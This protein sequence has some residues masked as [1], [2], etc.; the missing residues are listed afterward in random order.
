MPAPFSSG[1]ELCLWHWRDGIFSDTYHPPEGHSPWQDGQT[2]HSGNR[3]PAETKTWT[4]SL[5][6]MGRREKAGV[7]IK[8]RILLRIDHK[9]NW[10]ISFTLRAKLLRRGKFPWFLLPIWV[11]TFSLG[12]A[13]GCFLSTESRQR[14]AVQTSRAAQAALTSATAPHATATAHPGGALPG[15]VPSTA[16][17]EALVA[18]HGCRSPVWT[19]K[20]FLSTLP[21]QS[22][23]KMRD[24]RA[25]Q[26]LSKGNGNH[27]GLPASQYFLV[28]YL[29][30]TT[31]TTA[32]DK[33]LPPLCLKTAL[34]RQCAT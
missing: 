4:G 26:P 21:R 9:L 33:S 20:T 12:S 16:T 25:S 24:L 5:L 29:I 31:E 14:C 23:I 30:M 1:T 32:E 6:E 10:H 15:P 17:L 11:S 28:Q 19:T 2:H 18:A 13:R 8:F 7:S 27:A 34:N 22:L 3:Y